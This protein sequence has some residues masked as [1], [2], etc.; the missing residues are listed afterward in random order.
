MLQKEH[1][2]AIDLYKD[3]LKAVGADVSAYVFEIK[4]NKIRIGHVE[5]G[6]CQWSMRYFSPIEFKRM[7]KSRRLDL[8][9]G[10]P[11]KSWG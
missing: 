6:F 7:A 3:A 4:D 1:E 10:D 5:E 8:K 11:K 9:I 2:E